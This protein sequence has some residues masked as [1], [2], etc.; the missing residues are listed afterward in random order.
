M[1]SPLVS[2]VIPAYNEEQ[3][4]QHV[5]LALQKQT[6]KDFEV[7]V[8]DNNSTDETAT[9]AKSFG[10][11]VVKE[12]V[13]GMIPARERGFKEAKAE[14]IVRTDAD[15]II[16]TDW[17]ECYYRTFTNNPTIVAASGNLLLPIP[18]GRQ[19]IS[20]YNLLCRLTLHHPQ[21]NGPNMAIRKSIWKQLKVCTDDTKVHED[22]DLAIHVA[23]K[24]PIVFLPDLWVTYSMRRFKR[25]FFFT[26]LEYTFRQY[27]TIAYHQ[28]ITDF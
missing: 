23:K 9:I 19:I 21:L 24:G 18:F 17:V 4:L 25:S 13:Q 20:W 11:R 3:Y 10:V 15:T 5:L 14:I 28:K 8:V 26:L 2:I 6:F 22:I 16:P 12:P 1:T 7:I 27:K